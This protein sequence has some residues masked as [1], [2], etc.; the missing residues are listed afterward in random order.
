MLIYHG[1][2]PEVRKQIENYGN[3]ISDAIKSIL[4]DDLYSQLESMAKR[5]L[6]PAAFDILPPEE[7]SRAGAFSNTDALDSSFF[8]HTNYDDIKHIDIAADGRLEYDSTKTVKTYPQ[9]AI[10][11]TG[12][13]RK[14]YLTP[15]YADI[16]SLD[17]YM[18]EFLHFAVY[19]L[20]N[21]P[22][23]IA[24]NILLADLIKKGVKAT[25]FGDIN[26]IREVLSARETALPFATMHGLMTHEEINATALHA[27]IYRRAGMDGTWETMMKPFY[28][29]DNIAKFC[30]SMRKELDRGDLGTI[31]EWDRRLV[32]PAI[33]KKNFYR[34]IRSAIKVE[35]LPV[36]ELVIHQ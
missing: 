14:R 16:S 24:N 2:I 22:M 33:Y 27:E 10:T 30:D 13:D 12:I 8:C 31:F 20:Q 17:G 35:R 28:S 5:L 23:G 15:K 26:Q 6:I 7:L 34:D 18:H 29:D 4:K 25:S 19:C 21:I 1:N 11:P 32:S 3:Y 9:I 36:S